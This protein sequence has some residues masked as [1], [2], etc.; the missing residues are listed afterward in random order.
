M[1]AV[2]LSRRRLH[3]LWLLGGIG[4]LVALAALCYWLVPRP[5]ATA[6]VLVDGQETARYALTDRVHTVITTPYG[7]NTLTIE[8]GQAKITDADC[9]DGICAAHRPVSRAGETIVCLPHK[10]VIRIDR[11]GDTAPDMVV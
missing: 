5:G 8:N 1:R 6:V 2:S 9:P 4:V 7:I 10:L 3:D 11:A